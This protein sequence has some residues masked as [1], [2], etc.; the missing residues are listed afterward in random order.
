MYE[1]KQYKHIDLKPIN[2]VFWL[3]V[4]HVQ[5]VADGWG[6]LIRGLHTEEEQ[7][8]NLP[9]SDRHFCLDEYWKAPQ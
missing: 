2:F 6:F 9:A 8:P 4:L 5:S 7:C 1:T 3:N